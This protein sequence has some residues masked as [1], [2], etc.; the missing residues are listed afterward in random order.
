MRYLIPMISFCNISIKGVEYIEI[1]NDNSLETTNLHK[2]NQ[3]NRK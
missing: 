1:S 2:N 3:G